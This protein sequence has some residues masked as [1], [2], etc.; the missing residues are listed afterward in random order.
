MYFKSNKGV[1]LM[2]LTITIIV[3]L[4]ITSTVIY[5]TNNYVK[6]E[7]INK[8]YNDMESLN[9]KIEE[10]YLKFGEVPTV[11]NDVYCN[12]ETLK[13]LLNVNST[14]NNVELLTTDNTIINPNDSNEYYIIDLE[15]LDGLTLNYGYGSDYK[16]VKS[17][18]ENS[19]E[20]TINF[21]DL[22]IINKITHQIYYPNGVCTDDFMYYVYNLD[23]NKINL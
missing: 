3:M 22:Y 12:K 23:T 11:G 10:Y 5:N 6:T 9:A 16:K 15:K 2:A 4:I 13:N 1:T 21:D 17:M 20:I 7:K 18:I 14:V 19:E 8:L